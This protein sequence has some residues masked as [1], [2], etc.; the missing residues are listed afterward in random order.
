MSVPDAA[1]V[2]VEG[3]ERLKE[4]PD[5]NRVFLD[6][7]AANELKPADAACRQAG[8]CRLKGFSGFHR[9]YELRWN[10]P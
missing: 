4:I 5:R 6:E 7:D 2:A 1:F 9:V 10:G 8:V 3:E